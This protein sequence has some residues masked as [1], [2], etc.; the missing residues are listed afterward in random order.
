MEQGLAL[1]QSPLSHFQYPDNP[2]TDKGKG[3][4]PCPQ[5]AFKD[6]G[7]SAIMHINPVN[8]LSSVLHRST[9]LVIRG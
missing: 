4:N 7:I 3:V 2:H 5:Y 8:G 9:S 1:R 6:Q